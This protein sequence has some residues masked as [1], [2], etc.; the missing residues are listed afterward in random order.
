[1]RMDE[2]YGS[3][4]EDGALTGELSLRGARDE[5]GLPAEGAEA[6]AILTDAPELMEQHVLQIRRDFLLA[7]HSH[8]AR[9][10]RARCRSCCRRRIGRAQALHVSSRSCFGCLMLALLMEMDLHHG[11]INKR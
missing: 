7:A 8:Q 6:L 10:A 1:M 9:A 4:L 5:I 3:T 11:S 2:L